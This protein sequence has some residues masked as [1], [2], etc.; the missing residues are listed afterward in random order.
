[1]HSKVASGW[2]QHRRFTPKAHEFRYQ[3]SM[4]YLDLDEAPQLFSEHWLWSYQ[5]K[6]LA[7][8]LRQDHLRG[9]D[10]DLVSEVRNRIERICGTRPSGPVS[11]LT[12][13]RYWG[14]SMNPISLYFIW[15]PDRS[16]LEWL[17]LEVHNTPWNE[18]H[19]YILKA[20]EQQS[21]GLSMRFDKAMHVSPF[22]DMDMHYRLRLRQEPGKNMLITLENWRDEQRLL[23]THLQLKLT[24]VTASSL[25][26][27]LFKTPFMTL[28]IAAAIYYEALR[29]KLKGVPYV[30]YP[31]PSEPPFPEP[32]G[33]EK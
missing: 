3:L 28:K 6:N 8:I 2:V 19:P 18:Q 22:M 33:A 10:A 12:Q 20:P 7:C 17:L 31:G 14:Y 32:P 27:L 4:L 13:P 5:R 30:P 26:G 21:A 11:L 15:S 1:M 29:I 23:A 24:P 25:A 9:G 16:K